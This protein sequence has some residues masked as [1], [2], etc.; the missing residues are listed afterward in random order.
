MLTLPKIVERGSQPYVAIRERV[1]I[2]FN[3]AVDRAYGELFGWLEANGV[4]PAGAPFIKYN[5]I[6]MPEL[7]LEFGVPTAETVA[8]GGRVV[9][10]ALPPGRYAK[11]TYWGGYDNLM[12]VNAVLIG[13]AKEKGL[14]WDAAESPAGDRFASRLEIYETDP[15]R[16]PDKN[17]WQTEV[18]IKLG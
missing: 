7:E 2:P 18:A 13:W 14:R 1:R 4:T 10:G 15:K 11:V 5:L 9:A 16:E 17:K 12:D 3:D 8:A 6:A